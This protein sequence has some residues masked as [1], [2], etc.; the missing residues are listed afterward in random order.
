MMEH[1]K[2]MML[3]PETAYNTLLAHRNEETNPLTM[4]TCRVNEQLQSILNDESLAPDV[5]MIHVNNML[6]RYLM[7]KDQ[8]FGKN[9]SILP[10]QPLL[11]GQQ[12]GILPQT[13]I[14]ANT[15]V[16]T[17]LGANTLP[18]IQQQQPMV[19]GHVAQTGNHVT[20]PENT[21]ETRQIEIQT[22]N[23][24]KPK[25]PPHY[26]HIFMNQRKN[27]KEKATKLWDFIND[28]ADKVLWNDKFELV[29]DGQAVKGSNI[30]KL[31]KDFSLDKKIATNQ[32]G[33][34]EFGEILRRAH[35]PKTVIGSRRSWNQYISPN[36]GTIERQLGIKSK[37]QTG[38]G[39]FRIKWW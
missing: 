11:Q 7:L 36:T 17:P 22:E 1:T 3:V 29:H 35:V 30:I 13:L 28:N 16:Q 37:G 20:T 4:E 12:A 23:N 14:G 39:R 21:I 10:Q 34:K 2:K 26:Q 33:S 6:S 31:I 27:Y 25:L 18:Q 19:Q 24:E 32:H 9:T 15:L 5:K 38:S 8:Q